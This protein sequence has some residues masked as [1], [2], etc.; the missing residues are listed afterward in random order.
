MEGARETRQ[1]YY[2]SGMEDDDDSFPM[3]WIKLFVGLKND[4]IGEQTEARDWRS[5]PQTSSSSTLSIPHA[6]R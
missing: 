2:Y 4:G 1:Q 5:V 3:H 6:D